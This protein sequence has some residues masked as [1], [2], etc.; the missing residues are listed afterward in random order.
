MLGASLVGSNSVVFRYKNER[1]IS[2][3]LVVCEHSFI[4]SANMQG[5]QAGAVQGVK[6]VT[7]GETQPWLSLSFSLWE[8]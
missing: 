1:R 4:H 7:A 8:T 5:V 6:A 3:S 2:G